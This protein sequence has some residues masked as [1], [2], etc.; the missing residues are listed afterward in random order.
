MIS[1]EELAGVA[2]HIST[3][4]PVGRGDAAPAECVDETVVQ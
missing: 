4:S 3:R 2:W 1:P